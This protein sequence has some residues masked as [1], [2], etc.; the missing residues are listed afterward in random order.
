MV[1]DE[2]AEGEDADR[3]EAGGASTVANDWSP[4]LLVVKLLVL[5]GLPGMETGEDDLSGGSG[6]SEA[7]VED[8]EILL[9]KEAEKGFSGEAVRGLSR[10]SS[11]LKLEAGEEAEA[12]L[13]LAKIG[14]GKC[15]G[16][17]PEA[18]EAAEVF[19][20]GEGEDRYRADG[21]GEVMEA[22]EWGLEQ[23]VG[24]GLTIGGLLFSWSSW[25]AAEA[26]LAI[27]AT[28]NC[29]LAKRLSIL[30]GEIFFLI[31]AKLCFNCVCSLSVSSKDSST[32]P[33]T[34]ISSWAAAKAA[35]M[36]KVDL[37]P[38]LCAS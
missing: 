14:M 37:P 2:V 18:E 26:A 23:L 12:E 38:A 33:T 22:L 11:W 13:A 7:S 35:S 28:L 32:P 16:G 24:M 19:G 3:V 4:R 20:L 17:G 5:G 36:L 10:E 1:H 31:S 29:R 21:G 15:R 25:E 6:C 27:I 30:K 8:S 9:R 34:S